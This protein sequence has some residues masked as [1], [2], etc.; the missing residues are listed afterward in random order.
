MKKKKMLQ[1]FPHSQYDF[2][3]YTCKI[4][5]NFPKNVEYMLSCEINF[6]AKCNIPVILSSEFPTHSYNCHYANIT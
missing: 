1:K 6:G 5:E 4:L 2:V 3:D